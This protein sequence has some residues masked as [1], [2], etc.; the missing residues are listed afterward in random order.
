MSACINKKFEQLLYAYE[1]GMLSDEERESLEMHLLDCQSCR[2]KVSE[3]M[4]VSEI[5]RQSDELKAVVRELDEKAISRPGEKTSESNKQKT[6]NVWRMILPVAAAILLV[7][8]L[9]DW[10]FDIKPSKV[11]IAS[12]NKLVILPFTNIIDSSDAN[13]FGPITASLL[14]ADLTESHFVQI[15]S[16]QR[17]FDIRSRSGESLEG[18]QVAEKAGAKWLL[19]GDILQEK[20]NLEMTIN[21]I[22]VTSG[23]SISSI[24]ISGEPDETIFA[25]IDRL[26]ATIKVELSLPGEARTEN[27][28]A[29]ADV[30]THSPEAYRY[31]VEA[32]SNYYKFYYDDAIIGFEKAVQH[33]STFAMAY[34]YLSMLKDDKYIV[35]ALKYSEGSN[36]K[37]RLYIQAVHE[38]INNNGKAVIILLQQLLKRY[39][40]EKLAHYRI[41]YYHYIFKQSDLAEFHLKRALELDP[42]YK[43]PL[44]LLAYLYE[45]DSEFDKA[46]ETLDTYI[47]LA[48]EEANPYYTKGN[49]FA[50]RGDLDKAKAEYLTALE[51]KRDFTAAIYNLA[52]YSLFTLD[53]EQSENYSRMLMA[54]A[55]PSDRASGRYILSLRDVF[56][57]NF[58]NAISRLS[59][60]IAA[61]RLELKKGGESHV[62][63]TNY[64]TQTWLYTELGEFDSANAALK[65]NRENLT[66]VQKTFVNNPPTNYIMLLCEFSRM[67]EAAIEIEKLHQD[68]VEA[69]DSLN[70]YW[71]ARGYYALRNNDGAAAL[72][73][74]DSVNISTKLYIIETASAQAYYMSGQYDQAIERLEEI[75]STY[76]R[77]RAYWWPWTIRI[78]FYLAKSYEAIGE[79]E[80]AIQQYQAFLRIWNDEKVLHEDVKEAHRRLDNLINKI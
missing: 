25:M 57:G 39:P 20:P 53:Y 23:N 6:G 10:Q 78:P 62:I 36:F 5:I 49:I 28:P 2:S 75:N 76:S 42:M 71:F 3:M 18:L 17:I 60:A 66:S 68:L 11:A 21:V 1:L 72:K 46:I 67:D 43:Q 27:D 32:L 48:P 45:Q 16:N 54:S 40:D 41:G 80:K 31:Y 35:Q 52:M 50:R 4:K 51:K 38:S 37:E 19:T 65:K 29:V 8:I 56:E 64:L 30:T 44:S 77:W 12:E 22:E 70:S 47:S 63:S 58:R 26:S 33:D 24:K 73:C 79:T 34:Y 74:F 7:L 69:G 14:I 9:L 55:H 61:E 13:R 15:I 59:D